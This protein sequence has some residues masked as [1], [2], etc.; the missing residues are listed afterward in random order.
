MSTNGTPNRKNGPGAR[1]AIDI[2]KIENAKKNRPDRSP[3]PAS[4]RASSAGIGRSHQI[5]RSSRANARVISA[6]GT[7]FVSLIAHRRL[8]PVLGAFLRDV[9]QVLVE[10]DAFQSRERDEA[11]AAS[12]ADQRE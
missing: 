4:R 9:A 1:Y 2:Q 5:R 10:H 12:A 8:A 3:M 6:G 7:S 11:L